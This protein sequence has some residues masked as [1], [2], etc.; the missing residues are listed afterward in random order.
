MTAKIFQFNHH[1]KVEVVDLIFQNN[2]TMVF[3]VLLSINNFPFTLKDLKINNVNKDKIKYSYSSIFHNENKGYEICPFCN[4][5]FTNSICEPL[6]KEKNE[7]FSNDINEKIFL[8]MIF[9]Y[10]QYTEPSYFKKLLNAN[11]EGLK[12]L[13]FGVSEGTF[14][15]CIFEYKN[16][17]LIFQD[18]IDSNN[19]EFLPLIFYYNQEYQQMNLYIEY[20]FPNKLLPIT[21]TISKIINTSRVELFDTTGREL[22]ELYLDF[23]NNRL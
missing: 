9:Q 7:I 23:L 19:K 22:L 20:L 14:I 17:I 3:D 13:F 6:S 18:V 12:P 5:P 2:E 1:K 4:N 16:E 10:Y 15:Q 8:P 21:S 11:L